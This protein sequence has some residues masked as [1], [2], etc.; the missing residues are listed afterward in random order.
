MYTIYYTESL[1][2]MRIF[3]SS[4]LYIRFYRK[5]RRGVSGMLLLRK[6]MLSTAIL[7][8]RDGFANS[9]IPQNT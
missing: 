9:S 8:T 5:P 1:Q 3:T 2:R 4:V 6:T 7:E